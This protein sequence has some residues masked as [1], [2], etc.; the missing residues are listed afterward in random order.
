MKV[1]RIIA[2]FCLYEL[3]IICSPAISS[4]RIFSYTSRR[5][6]RNTESRLVYVL[7]DSLSDFFLNS[8]V[9]IHYLKSKINMVW[10]QTK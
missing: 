4:V 10:C 9:Y 1:I 8:T 6:G 3:P 7:R 5:L 2:K